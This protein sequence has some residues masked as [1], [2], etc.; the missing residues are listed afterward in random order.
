MKPIDFCLLHR[1]CSEGVQFATNYATMVE[2]W[3]NC[4]RADWLLWILKRTDKGPGQKA[5]LLFACWC[6]R[7]TPLADGRKV[8]DLLTNERSR[9][10]VVVTEK[11]AVGAATPQELRAARSDAATAAGDAA[12]YAGDAYATAAAAAYADAY[13]AY[14]ADAVAYAAA[15]AY[16]A[17]DAAYAADGA[18]AILAVSLTTAKATAADAATAV[19]VAARTKARA[20]QA[21]QFRLMFPNPFTT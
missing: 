7:N 1:A 13:A 15:A 2:V 14:A 17:A 4:P 18:N 11:F 6:V 8:W 10:A 21:D 12:A 20:V 9:N 19:A 3:D 5:L 16:V